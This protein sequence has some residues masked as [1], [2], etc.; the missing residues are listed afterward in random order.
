MALTSILEKTVRIGVKDC[1]LI[2]QRVYRGDCLGP[3]GLVRGHELEIHT[4]NS[5]RELFLRVGDVHI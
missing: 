2:F 3:R 5:Y 1:S 4:C